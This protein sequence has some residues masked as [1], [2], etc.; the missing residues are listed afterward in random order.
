MEASTATATIVDLDKARADKDEA[1][2][3]ATVKKTTAKAATPKV[4]KAVA[5][6]KPKAGDGKKIT[7]VAKEN[8][9]RKGTNRAK[10]WAK[11][12]TGMTIGEVRAAG[13]PARF[14]K[15]MKA[16]GHIKIG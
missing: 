1:K 2:A 3:K 16:G 4:T 15:K 5:I 14:I 6:V 12:K 9:T 11:L 13:I 10:F 7:I 8:P